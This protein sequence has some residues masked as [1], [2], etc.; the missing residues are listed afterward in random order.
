MAPPCVPDN[1]DGGRDNRKYKNIPDLRNERRRV[2]VFDAR[3]TRRSR[4]RA[5]A[6]PFISR[7]EI[8]IC[9]SE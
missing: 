2:C 7:N 9:S 5:P 1:D 4:R 8:L 6:A 3:F